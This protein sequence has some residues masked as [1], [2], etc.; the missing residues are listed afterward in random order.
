MNKRPFRIAGKDEKPRV[1][2]ITVN[3]GTPH[4]IRSLLQGVETIRPDF[5]FEYLVVDNASGDGTPE[6]VREQFPWATVIASP[7]NLG[8]GGGNNLGLKAARGEYIFLCNPD[9]V[10]LEGELESWLYW[11]DAHPDVGISCPRVINPDGSDQHATY[12]FPKALTPLYRRSF[13]G[14]L[15]FARREL[16]RYLMEDMDRDVEQDV[17]WVFGAAM[18]IR[19]ELLERI[20]LF[21]E[22]FFMYFEDADLCRRV[23]E[24]GSRVCYTPVARVIHYHKRESRTRYPWQAFTNR[25][26]R[27]HW[28]SGMKYFLKH[29][30]K[31]HPRGTST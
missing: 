25:L 13:V 4:F 5:D 2:F 27:I 8:F 3:H 7:E 21:D 6:M 14:R 16:N 9:L 10:L 20:G 18:L 22:R 28:N 23:W 29:R 24:S 17:D 26:T 1:S 12:R 19:R 11:M 30:G 15:P 31:A